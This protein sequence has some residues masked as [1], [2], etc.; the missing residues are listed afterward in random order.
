MAPIYQASVFEVESLEQLDD[1][2][3]GRED[4]FIYTR[5]GNPN[6]GCLEAVIAELEDADD[7]V[8]FASG[9]GAIGNTLLSMVEAGDTVLA[10]DVLYGG[11]N[12]LL[13]KH[14]S[15][16]G[17]GVEFVDV[18]DLKLVEKALES[19][20][21]VLLVES[22]T[23]PLLRVT[24]IEGIARLASAKGTRVVVDNTLAT[25]LLM[26]PL[27]LGADV[28]LHSATK[29]LGGHSDV[30]G[31]VAAGRF[32][33]MASVRESN[34]VW[35]STLD[36]FAAWLII[37]G[38]RTLPLRVARVCENAMQIADYLSGHPAVL[39]VHYPGLP[40]HPDHELA[41]ST[42]N[43]GFGSMVS[44]EVRGGVEGASKFIRALEMIRFAASLG[45]TCTTVSHP[46][47][48]SHR[49]L[50]DGEREEVGIYGGLI[51]MSCGIEFGEDIEAD[52]MQALARV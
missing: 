36:P 16:F 39:A 25:P 22:I 9:M 41:G 42:L 44:F 46:A 2:Y 26:R 4:G 12:L 27:S 30:M 1:I 5:D 47:K 8:A 13:R 35:G 34:R 45:E 52:L 49:A 3:A 48:T 23:N 43:G 31:G 50:T 20:P 38:I 19:G 32:E 6:V 29:L 14:L 18:T 33:T 28:T 24:D 21:E 37:R 40:S 11:T 17:V 10:G 51:R 15:K 7:A